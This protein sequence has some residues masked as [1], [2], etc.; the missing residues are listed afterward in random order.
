MGGLHYFLVSRPCCVEGTALKTS[1]RA[2]LIDISVDTQLNI[3][4]FPVQI[5]VYPLKANLLTQHEAIV[6]VVLSKI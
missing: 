1:T 4:L 2:H 3:V 5:C 6:P